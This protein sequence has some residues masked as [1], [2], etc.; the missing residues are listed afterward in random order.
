[1]QC[2]IVCSTILLLTEILFTTILATF[3]IFPE[4]LFLVVHSNLSLTSSKW[5]PDNSC[6]KSCPKSSIKGLRPS[7][8]ETGHILAGDWRLIK[9]SPGNQRINNPH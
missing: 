2:N 9:Q 4:I 6:K 3:G 5:E 7:G 8:A 1:M